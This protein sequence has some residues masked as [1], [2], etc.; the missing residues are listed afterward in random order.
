MNTKRSFYIMCGV[1]GLLFCLLI[2]SVISGN[3]W[4]KKQ[5]D[6]LL[7]AKLENRLVDE[8][9]VALV[10]ANK[11]IEKYA[12][13]EQIAN[14]IVPQ[15]KDQAKTVREIVSLADQNGIPI[16]GVTFPSSTLGAASS[17]SSSANS[18]TSSNS[19]T[20]P[21][22]TT[23]LTQVTPVSG[24]SGVYQMLI[25][26]QSDTSRPVPYSSFVSFLKDIETNRRTAQVSTMTILPYAKDIRKITF[27]LGINVYIR[28]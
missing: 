15:D 8:Q 4:L 20:T 10:R 18:S 12:Q 1:V 21:S 17:S 13:L 14:S 27:T 7:T 25:T 22:S 9:Q 2:L 26:V 3:M 28:P 16:S 19:T 23:N 6:K 11:D 24:M 5:S